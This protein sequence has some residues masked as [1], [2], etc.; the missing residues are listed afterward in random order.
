[1]AASVSHTYQS[2]S[3]DQVKMLIISTASPFKFTRS[4]MNAISPKYDSMTD[5]TLIDELS[6][7][8]GVKVPQAIE[9]IR[10]AKVLHTTI[11]AKDKMQE[12]VEEILKI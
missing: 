2:A 10:S 4:V 12:I 8:S 6:G 1:M 3:G 11:C 7:L 5:L 9:D